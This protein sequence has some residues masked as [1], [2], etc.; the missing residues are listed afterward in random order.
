MAAISALELLFVLGLAA[1]LGGLALGETGRALDDSRASGAARYVASRLREARME[2]VAR[3]HNTAVGVVA[4]PGGFVVT[5][6]EDG[7][8]NGVTARDISSGIDTA[9]HPAESLSDRFPGVDFATLTGLPAVDAAEAPPGPDP[10]HLGVADRASF[11]PLGT[12]TP[13]SLYLLGR[14]GRQY[15]VRIFGETGRTR[16]LRFDEPTRTWMPVSGL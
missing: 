14:G 7:N 16:V 2:A 3:G 1:T 15:V 13:G 8:G 12:A 11:T 6:Y 4:T 9:I 5:A 10:I